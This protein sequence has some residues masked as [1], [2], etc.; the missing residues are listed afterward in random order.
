MRLA[1]FPLLCLI[2][3]LSAPAAQAETAAVDI[4]AAH[5]G[6]PDGCE[7]GGGGAQQIPSTGPATCSAGDA[8][9]FPCN[10]IDLGY[11]FDIDDIGGGE[12][13]D[14]WGWTDPGSFEEYAI[15]G[16]TTGTA[17]IDVTD[18][19][20]PVYLGDLPTHDVPEIW[21]DVKVYA[22]HAFIVSESSAHGLQIFDLTQLSSVV[23]PPVT[24]AETAHDA[25]FGN[26]HNIAINESSGYGYVVGSDQCAGGLLMYDVSVPAAVTVAGCYSGDGYTH[27][28]QCINYA[29]PD[30]DYTG[31]EVCFASNEDSLTIVDVTSKVAPS[32]I[33]KTDYSGRDY[34]HQSWAT[35]DHAWLLQDDEGDELSSGHNTRTYIVDIADLDAP[36]FGSFFSS[37][38]PA[39]DH[40]QYVVGDYVFQANY[41]AGLRILDI[42]S[43][44]IGVLCEVA[45]FDTF[46]T[47]NGPNFNGAWS[48]YPFFPSGTVV[49]NSNIGLAVLEPNHVGA[50]CIA[51][52]PI[53]QTSKQQACIVAANKAGARVAKTQG[54]VGA[55]CVS[56]AT[57]GDPGNAQACL[58]ADGQQKVAKA[59]AKL[60]T[61]V[62]KK[63]SGAATPDFGLTDVPTIAGAA[64]GEQVALMG[65]IYGS[66]LEAA[67]V[68]SSTDAATAKCQSSIAKSHDRAV[69]A[70]LKVFGACKKLGL[71]AGNIGNTA[72]LAAC[73]DDVTAD[74]KGKIAKAAG[75]IAST[76]AGTCAAVAPALALPGECAA[77]GDVSACIDQR[78]ACRMCTMAGAF[79]GLVLD[80]DLF[81]DSTANASCGP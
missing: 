28:V 79:D 36:V 52:P 69:Q 23:A 35:D 5:C 71:K 11:W 61:T 33:S 60:V 50:A 13:N 27:D 67:I 54:K 39:I 77:A 40:N 26:A 47:S 7:G 15:V 25:G 58:S 64:V 53:V 56:A 4:V 1:V 31:A 62:A 48:S 32:Q 16:R 44:S 17:F 72:G 29:G 12:G 30:S 51:T 76:L 75:K 43:I 3:A 21:R 46:P 81:D 19:Q 2:V 37:H 80:C 78:A 42:S 14:V 66:D 49:V 68:E 34:T 38:L 8:A 70:R 45:S 55:R 63:C 73:L 18:P 24:F 74:G 59:E 9:G 6:H 10:N 57:K 41:S 20:N 65:D 22:D